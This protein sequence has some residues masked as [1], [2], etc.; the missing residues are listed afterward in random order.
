MSKSDSRF[1]YEASLKRTDHDLSQKFGFTCAP[2][3]LLPIWTDFASPHDSYYINHDLSFMRT[4]P[5]IAPAMIDVTVHYETFFV[6]MQMIYQPFENSYFS[7]KPILS[8]MF[9]PSEL[10][11]TRLP[12]YDYTHA[13]RAYYI[14]AGSAADHEEWFGLARLFDVIGLDYRTM[15]GDDTG[16]TFLGESFTGFPYALAAYQCCY[17]HYYR[18][19]DKEE[20]TNESYNLD[21]FYN[22][23][24]PLSGNELCML[25]YRPWRFDFFTS[26]YRSPIIS[27]A[28]AQKMLPY[29][30]YTD[31]VNIK[32][33]PLGMNTAAADLANLNNSD[34]TS[35]VNFKNSDSSITG[36]ANYATAAIRQMFANEKLAMITGRTRKNYDSQVLAHFGVNVP[37]DVKHDITLIGHDE[38]RLQI[39]EV[40][41]LASTEASPLGELAGKGWSSDQNRVGGKHQHKFTAPCHGVVITIFSVEPN[42]R[43]DRCPD[44]AQFLTNANEFPVP[45]FDRLGN[46]PMYRYETGLQYEGGYRPQPAF[47]IVAWKERYYPFKRKA[48]RVSAA[49]S[50]FGKNQSSNNYSSYFIKGVPFGTFNYITS[51]GSDI[52]I[53]VQAPT[54]AAAYTIQP[55]CLDDL[56]LVAYNPYFM[57]GRGD[58]AAENWLEKP[59]LAY[60]RDPFI[61]DSDIKVK[62]VSWMSKDGEPI[63]D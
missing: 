16:E 8:S 24:E 9:R 20:F 55:N 56:M 1:K 5:L 51:A 11:N 26:S 52:G 48:D 7:L 19:D 12:V 62:K 25:R 49:F 43:Y 39:G 41:S 6:P 40:T 57:D 23:S 27:D 28:N 37:H 34:I 4:A 2:G 58:Y 53:E 14:G 22:Q 59:F 17:Q 47:D 29:G 61:V 18:L 21:Q 38:F 32:T 10:M 63:Y 60:V 15:F 44:R 35:F 54:S 31:L 50:H 42:R 36:N 45:E 30:S 33:S 46:Q 13:A 3:M